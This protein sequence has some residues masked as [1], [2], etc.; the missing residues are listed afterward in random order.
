MPIALNNWTCNCPTV[1]PGDKKRC[2]HCYAWQ[3]SAVTTSAG[4]DEGNNFAVE[5][6]DGKLVGNNAGEDRYQSDDDLGDDDKAS[7]A[8]YL[9][10][11]VF[12]LVCHVGVCIVFVLSCNCSA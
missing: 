6:N 9:L 8:L 10:F 4:V 12:F 3:F 2:G 1:H 7:V 11:L 5:D